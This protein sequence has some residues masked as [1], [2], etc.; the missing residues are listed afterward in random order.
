MTIHRA[1]NTNKITL[2]NIFSNLKCLK[3]KIVFPIHPRTKK[4]IDKENI[5][6]PENIQL[7]EPVNYINMSILE[8]YSQFII[9]DSGGI[10]P[11]AYFLKKKCIILRS[12]TEWIEAIENNNNILYDYKT[13]LNEFIESFLQV[14]VLKEYTKTNASKNIVNIINKLKL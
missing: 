4:I 14:K 10:Q 13:P 6:I 2:S 8:R 1:Y 5:L 12:E 9:T 11:E 7:I 3:Y